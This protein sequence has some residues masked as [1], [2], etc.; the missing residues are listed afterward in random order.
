MTADAPSGDPR[1]RPLADAVLL[2][3]GGMGPAADAVRAACE[4]AAA[5][6]EGPELL[7]LA[8]LPERDASY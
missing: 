4:A 6:A 2:W 5:G 3:C 8:A 1:V 7:M